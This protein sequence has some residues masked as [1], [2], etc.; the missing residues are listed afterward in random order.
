MD[1]PERTLKKCLETLGLTYIIYLLFIILFSGFVLFYI[2][3]HD[4]GLF[5]PSHESTGTVKWIFAI[6]A[7]VLLL[8]AIFIH[9]KKIDNTIG[10]NSLDKKIEAY[11]KSYL[12]KISINSFI[13]IVDSLLLLLYGDLNLLIPLIFFILYFL[14]NRP[15]I[16]KISG[17]LNL[18]PA[19]REA[20]KE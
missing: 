2:V 5:K 16:E 18:T 4:R 20:L 9:R 8:S 13:C 14:L 10:L 1:K 11:L 12:V 6:L 3:T 7:V 15:Y 19:E 17:E